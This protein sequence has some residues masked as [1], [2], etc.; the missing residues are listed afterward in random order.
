MLIGALLFYF[1]NP[2]S[3][4]SFQHLES[5]A[6]THFPGEEIHP[7]FSP[8]GKQIAF[9]WAE[10]AGEDYDI[11]LQS[12]GTGKPLR[13]V[14]HPGMDFRPAW[15]PDGHH[16]VFARFFE[17]KYSI[18]LVPA[19][20]GAERQLQFVN[21]DQHWVYQNV[22]W[23]P[24]GKF[25]ALADRESSH[26]P[27]SIYLLSLEKFEKKKLTSP[28]AQYLGDLSSA[29]SP[30][31]KK[32]AFIRW[33]SWHIMGM[34]LIPVAGGEAQQLYDEKGFIYGLTWTPDGREIVFST[35]DGLWR[36]PAIGGTPELL[37]V[38]GSGQRF[39]NPAISRQGQL[40]YEQYNIDEDI[41]RMEI[42]AAEGQSP[43]PQ[44]FQVAAT[45]PDWLQDISPDG[46]R[47]VFQWLNESHQ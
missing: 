33:T 37:P 7:A 3:K 31:G 34:Y 12:P 19:L 40:A 10:V 1:F 30:D 11:Y 28:P 17:G 4:T 6:L 32:L 26:E 25:L 20:G 39:E 41:W 44:P 23:S 13:L 24:D 16:L 38:I 43:A 9:A 27:Q 36:I 29:F 5:I 8:S 45:R 47:V 2:F 35:G 22:S 18:H 14:N 15:S 21:W 46:R 42:P